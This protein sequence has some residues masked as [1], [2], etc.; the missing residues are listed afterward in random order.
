MKKQ[1]LF[2]TALLAAVTAY[3]QNNGGKIR[4]S[5]TINMVQKIAS[6]F[7]NEP[8][9][10]TTTAKQNTNPVANV[11]NPVVEPQQASTN[12]SATNIGWKLLT[13]SQNVYGML[14]SASHPLQ[15]NDNLNAVSFV[16]RKSASYVA[17]PTSNSGAIV[18]EISTNWG[19]TW[20][21][22][23]IWS[24]GTNLA[25]YP[26]GAIYNPVGNTN[27]ANAYIVGAGPVTGGSGWLGNWY[28][29][30]QLGTGNYNATASSTTNAQQFI[31]NA[32]PYPANSGKV[33]FSRI[34]F[35]TTDDGKVHL[36]GGI[37][38]DANGTTAAAQL[39]R[40][41]ALVKGTYNAGVF[42]WT[43]DS[44]I[45]NTVVT[46][47]GDKVVSSEAQ[48]AWNEAGTVGYVV[49]IGAAATATGSNKNYQPIVYKSTNSGATWAL[50]NGIDFNAN[51]A[52]P[53]KAPIAAIYG[54]TLSSTPVLPQFNTGEGWGVVVDANNKLHIAATIIGAASPH[55][56]SLGYAYTYTTSI[57]PNDGY[58]WPH[59]KG[60]HP[61]LY[62]FYGD[63]TTAWSYRT[64][65]SLSSEGPTS[66]ATQPA[67]A[68]FADNQWDN[69]GTGGAK[70]ES[71]SRIQLSRTPDG[72][73][74]T[75]SW[76]ESDSTVTN[77]GK[78]W[79]NLPNIKSRCLNATT[80]LLSTTEINV[81]K[82]AVGQGT[83]NAN[84][85]NRATLFYI[86]ATTSSATV[87]VTT[88]I[89]TPYTVTNSNP[90]SQLTNNTTWYSTNT[91]SYSSFIL[92]TK[93]LI[94]NTCIIGVKENS[95]NEAQS[96]SIFPNPTK[97]N[98]TLAID[99]KENT[100][101]TVSIYNLVGAL[102][103]TTT[104]NATIGANTI[105]LDLSNLTSGIYMANVKVGNSTSTK[106]LIIE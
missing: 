9:E 98:A 18:A 73:Y 72:Q 91:L 48:M 12:V 89:K 53:I 49:F 14:V 82:V 31:A 77:G 27:I 83:N 104:V 35:V 51:C 55:N 54:S 17:S 79:N 1:L 44:I 59:V 34:S 4:P 42:V 87:G 90:Y 63:G 106:K 41:A 70:I 57:N 71:D 25:R 56:D 96:S 6:K 32:G 47:A 75:Y 45:P 11:T 69:T 85:A 29:S 36:T 99:V 16:H 86:S 8:T 100:T 7:A 46:S 105:N 78:K 24:D 2:G 81:S 76:S 65:D 38:G 92:P 101:V 13:G 97:V 39:Y 3:S 95:L 88:D 40:G 28:A 94:N 103:K 23:C 93:G 22:T 64:V 52:A 5:G 61:Y 15:Y 30:K 67:T 60:A 58:Q 84:V 26:S 74:I 43:N 68:G 66:S 19:T 33:D 102:V 20:D 37:Y 21:S 50:L 80:D 62:D 10:A